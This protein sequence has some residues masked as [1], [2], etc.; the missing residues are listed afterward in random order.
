ME[1]PVHHAHSSRTSGAGNSAQACIVSAVAASVLASMVAIGC[2]GDRSPLT[3]ARVEVEPSL[4]SAPPGLDLTDWG[5]A[6]N[7]GPIVNSSAG[8]LGPAISP[9]GLALYFYS[10]RPGGSGGND[11]WV[12]RRAHRNAPWETPRNL[13]P[14][15]NSAA[16]DFVPGLSPDGHELL[17]G[18]ARPGGF[19]DADLWVSHRDDTDDDLSW[20]APVNLG[21][22]VNSAQVDAAPYLVKVRDELT[23]FF[24]RGPVINNLDLYMSILIDGAFGPHVPIAELNTS[25]AT[26]AHAT[27][28]QSEH[29][30]FFYS[31][32]TG[33]A[34]LTDIWT[35]TR[36]SANRPW[37]TPVNVSR[38]NTSSNEFHPSLDAQGETLFF[39]SDR[40]GGSGGLDLYMATRK[41]RH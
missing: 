33:G 1:G 7:L 28:N 24:S 21:P 4:A 15:I 10:S 16:S 8:D 23:L 37:N 14:L 38:L 11:L 19:G 13:G 39:A 2:S 34:G 35:S 36:Q 29:E 9:D 18:S 32:R 22:A 12:S 40:P 17:F 6:V 3:P 31:S 30:I 25:T 5:P 26:E 27:L 41:R 20:Q